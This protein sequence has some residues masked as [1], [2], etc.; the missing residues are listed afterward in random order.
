MK[1]RRMVDR[2]S[3]A[4]VPQAVREVTFYDDVLIVAIVGDEAYVA[5]RPITDFLGL[6][7]SAQFRRVQRDEV[8]SSQTQLVMMAGADGRQREMLSLPL[9]LLPGWLFGITVSKARPEIAPKLTRYRRECFR[10]LWNAFQAEL[11]QH[12]PLPATSNALTQVRDLALAVAQMAEQQ[13][14]LQTQVTTV[15]AKIDQAVVIV[16]S[17]ER[18]LSVVEQRTEPAAYITNA[19]A[20]E[21]SNQVKALAEILTSKDTSKNHY[22]G[23]FGE[24]YRRF[25][26]SSYKLIRQEQYQAV[27]TFLDRWRR[28]IQKDS[29]EQGSLF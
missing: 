29:P 5:L 10:V 3:V 20:A 21:V 23:I 25:G 14:E 27:L 17:L 19:Q 28:T 24:L 22:Q 18:R 13:M 16:S 4:L 7:W 15:N 11:I 6:E 12:T 26:V 9:D 2:P 8:L 1:G